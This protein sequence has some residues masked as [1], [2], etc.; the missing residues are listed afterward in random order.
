MFGMNKPGVS[1]YTQIA[2]ETGVHASNPVQLIVMLY[3]GAI[4]ACH[5]AVGYMQR[6]EIESKGAMLAKAIMIIESGLR[7]SLD[8]KA[9]GEIAENLDALY[10]YMTARLATAN[11]RNQPEP[12]QEVIRLL[13]ELKVS[14][15][16]LSRAKSGAYA[17]NAQSKAVQPQPSAP[18][19]P[20]SKAS[21]Y[22]V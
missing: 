21:A 9:G 8:K 10:A 6:G 5:S 13:N 3:E 1:G 22:K 17:T 4:T 20:L 2:V 16:E 12:V 11:V 15:E 7:L 18:V 19:A 14:W